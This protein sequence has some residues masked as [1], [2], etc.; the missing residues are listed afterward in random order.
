MQS[1]LTPLKVPEAVRKQL[2]EALAPWQIRILGIPPS[3]DHHS[4]L[5]YDLLEADLILFSGIGL[6]QEKEIVEYEALSY[7]CG[8][9]AHDRSMICNGVSFP[10]SDT[11]HEA[12]FHI[13]K[14]E[15][16]R[17]LWTDA[18]CIDQYDVE[19]KS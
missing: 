4:E 5:T 15:Q 8:Y 17:Y 7:S 12:L 2:Y 6:V 13:R 9:P 19:E 14:D 16:I 10:V 1:P 11:L 18:C 3:A